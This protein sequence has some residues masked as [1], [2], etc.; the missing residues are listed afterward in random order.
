M[1]K[2]LIQLAASKNFTF[3]RV[4]EFIEG[5]DSKSRGEGSQLG[6]AG[7]SQKFRV[8]SLNPSFFSCVLYDS[9]LAGECPIAIPLPVHPDTCGHTLQR[10]C[11]FNSGLADWA[12]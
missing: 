8:L 12:A 7:T 6:D 2:K 11:Q 4:D 1:V 5:T 10:Y 9:G 3:S